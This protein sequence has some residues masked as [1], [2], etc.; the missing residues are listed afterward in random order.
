MH[1]PSPNLLQYIIV[2]PFTFTSSSQG[3]M[4]RKILRRILH[5]I[6][7][8]NSTKSQKYAKN[9]QNPTHNQ[10]VRQNK[11]RMLP[12]YIYKTALKWQKLFIGKVLRQQKIVSL[13][14]NHFDY[15]YFIWNRK[16][17]LYYFPNIISCQTIYYLNR[18]LDW[19]LL[20]SYFS[21]LSYD[22]KTFHPS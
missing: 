8:I 22:D 6:K 2:S 20:Q 15:N 5:S 21:F 12:Y 7:I 17:P 10:R 16:Y 13:H 3:K 9:G 4:D 11:I 14:I 1:Y 18:P 19:F